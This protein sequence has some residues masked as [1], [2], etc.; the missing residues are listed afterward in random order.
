VKLRHRG[1]TRS[2]PVWV[3]KLPGTDS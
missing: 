2:I 1:H 3:G